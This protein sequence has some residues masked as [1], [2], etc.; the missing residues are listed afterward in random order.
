MKKYTGNP[1]STIPKR[2]GFTVGLGCLMMTVILPAPTDMTVFAWHTAGIAM[3]L[4]AWW[5]TE[6]LPIPITS[7]LPILLFPAFGILTTGES[8]APYAAP[9]IFLLFGGFIIATGLTKWNLHRR[10][11]LKILSRIGTS[12]QAIIAGFMG[13]TALLSM[14]ISN[15]ASAIMMMPIALSLASD[16]TKTKEHEKFLLCLILGIAYAAS[17]GGLG[18]IIGTPPNLL[19]VGYMKQTYGIEISFLEWMLLGIPV[20]LIMITLTWWMLT[21][22][23]YPFDGKNIHLSQRIITDELDKMGKFTQPEKRLTIVFL[24][25]AIA[26]IFRIPV[27]QHFGIFLWLDDAM[28]AIGGAVMLFLIPSG[29]AQQ[30][31]SAL[32]DWESANKIPWGVLLLFGAGLS[33]AAAIEKTGLAGWLS[34]SLAALANLELFLIMLGLVTL[35]IF[36]T[37]LTSNTATTATLLPILGALAM[38]HGIEPMLLIAPAALAASC[39][40]MLPIATAPNAVVYATGHVAI[41]QMAHAGFKLN[42][43]GIAVLTGISYLIV[44]RLFG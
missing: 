22:W 7:L 10:L 23:A 16:I 14:W 40:F 32:L 21:K 8:T 6:V 24:L 26:W 4:A 34:N 18:T 27:Q 44:P 28:I 33:L 19:V 38:T 1:F 37:E 42:L 13:A 29:H 2:I 30:K 43:I 15:T 9:I 25:V 12:P 31:T 36:L 35:V 11:A 41:A 3:L 39:A 17:I 20:V 5:A